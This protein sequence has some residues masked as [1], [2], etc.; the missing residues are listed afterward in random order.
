MI[1]SIITLLFQFL[2][3]EISNN[4]KY[5]AKNAG[6]TILI[7]GISLLL[8]LTF[9]VTCFVV[10]TDLVFSKF[11]F[12]IIAIETLSSIGNFGVP[13]YVYQKLPILKKKNQKKELRTLIK[14]ATRV[15]FWG[16][17]IMALLAT[18][19][20]LL[21]ARYHISV[22]AYILFILS[23]PA[24]GILRLRDETLKSLGHTIS[25]YIG[26]DILGILVSCIGVLL[27]FIIKGTTD[28]NTVVTIYSIGLV[29]SFIC[30]VLLYNLKVR[31][32]FAEYDWNLFNVRWIAGTFAYWN[33]YVIDSLLR[34]ALYFLL[35]HHH[36]LIEGG[37]YVLLL[38]MTLMLTLAPKIINNTLLPF[39]YSS[40]QSNKNRLQVILKK[41]SQF[42]LLISCTIFTILVGAFE[43]LKLQTGIAPSPWLLI[44]LLLLSSLFI[45]NYFSPSDLLLLLNKNGKALLRSRIF[46]LA[47]QL[48][49]G[50]I[51][52]HKM[53]AL[54]AAITFFV[55]KL[56]LNATQYFLLRKNTSLKTGLI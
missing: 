10:C 19:F 33:L 21:L 29:V 38:E 39:F 15:S 3:F 11:I 37:M 54:G 52:I 23:I 32:A 46:C 47:I 42:N 53:G 50:W 44:F 1:K 36:G 48:I 45:E 40:L 20:Y 49:L 30:S 22:Y 34:I 2:P 51:L 8:R 55:S 43:L 17:L 26:Y 4:Q 24:N 28:F 14:F 13:Q 31:L 41:S 56:I 9:F 16:N 35:V 12:Y 5:V 7:N 27:I 18:I 25:G 6:S